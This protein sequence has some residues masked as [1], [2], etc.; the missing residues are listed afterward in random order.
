[1][2]A[3]YSDWIETLDSGFQLDVDYYEQA[4]RQILGPPN[5]RECC[6]L[7]K[8]IQLSLAGLGEGGYPDAHN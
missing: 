6:D 3:K 1:M 5:M 2:V 7:V 4:M 8:L